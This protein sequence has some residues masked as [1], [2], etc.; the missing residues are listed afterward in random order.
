MI[1]SLVLIIGFLALAMG[2]QV[3]VEMVET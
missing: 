3:V 1:V 2:L